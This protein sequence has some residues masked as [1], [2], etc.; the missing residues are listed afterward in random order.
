[1]RF[2]FRA[3]SN[4]VRIDAKIV[5]K[6]GLSY[7]CIAQK[8]NC[9]FFSVFQI[10]ETLEMKR[11]FNYYEKQPRS[12]RGTKSLFIFVLFLCIAQKINCDLFSAV[13]LPPKTSIIIQNKVFTVLKTL[14]VA[15]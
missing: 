9:D 15:S 6:A 4:L 12:R 11:L 1:M 5:N 3:V 7:L 2:H 14:P 13:L 10:V 8:I